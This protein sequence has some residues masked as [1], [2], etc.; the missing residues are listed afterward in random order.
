MIYIYFLQKTINPTVGRLDDIQT[1][2]M[3]LKNGNTFL[4][5]AESFKTMNRPD[6]TLFDGLFF[7]EV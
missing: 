3:P 5:S 6:V 4:G 7:R 2:L 1:A